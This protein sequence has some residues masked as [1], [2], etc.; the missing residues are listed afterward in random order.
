MLKYACSVLK[1]HKKAYYEQKEK[2]IFDICP[3]LEKF[4]LENYVEL[5]YN[6][7][8]KFEKRRKKM[9]DTENM[10]IGKA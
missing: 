5:C 3:Q 2:M 4:Y 7:T 1:M 9:V 8:I 6:K 10:R